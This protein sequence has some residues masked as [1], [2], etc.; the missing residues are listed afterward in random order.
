[1]KVALL[2]PGGV[3]RSGAGKVIPCLLSIIEHLAAEGHDVHVFALRQ[4]DHPGTWPLLGAIVHNAGSQPR[5][6]RMLAMIV[7]EHR[8]SPF[9]VLHAFWSGQGAIGAVAG[10]LLRIPLVLTLPGGDVAALP[11]IG[12]GALLSRPGRLAL[13]LAVRCAARVNTP[14][15]F[16][17]DLAAARGIRAAVLP[18]G[19]DL[20]RWPP[21]P[22]RPR[23][24]TRPLKLLHVA[25][26][27]RVKD[28]PTLLE[29]MGRL[30]RAG[31]EFELVVIGFDTL[32]GETQRMAKQAGLAARFMGQLPHEDLRPWYVWADLLVM[33]SRHE[34][35][36]L[37]TLEAAIAGVPT[38]GTHVGHIADLAPQAALAVPVGDARA[39]AEAVA[40]LAA[41]EQRRL[42]L[43]AAAQA[44]A[45]RFD[46]RWTVRALC[47]AYRDVRPEHDQIDEPKDL[48]HATTGSMRR[49]SG[50][51][52]G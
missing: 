33:S 8:K 45:L 36:P 3:D 47:E 46:A 4:E 24:R 6:M 51:M 40:N 37:V 14:S 39:L 26:L 42:Q 27:N 15:R 7:A 9:A 2:V 23:D 48:S 31:V 29:A 16:M 52:R 25:S 13:R 34:A 21:A 18:L 44:F 41:N 17:R 11:D 35:G 30:R 1:M 12:Y 32:N 20:A 19:V 50:R 5:G 38:V 49:R 43:A 10:T 22:P 28:Q